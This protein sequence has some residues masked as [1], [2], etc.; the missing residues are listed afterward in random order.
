MVGLG[1]LLRVAASPPL[2]PGENWKPWVSS[3]NGN[4]PPHF[5]LLLQITQHFVQPSSSRT[6][7]LRQPCLQNP[8]AQ[9]HGAWSPRASPGAP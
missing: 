5:L 6:T 1:V 2:P 8:G 3:Y 4:P 9:P 7:S